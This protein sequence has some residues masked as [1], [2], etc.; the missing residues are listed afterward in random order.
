MELV[1]RNDAN[2]SPAVERLEEVIRL[3]VD[4]QILNT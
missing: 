4:Q 1:K 3:V 2:P